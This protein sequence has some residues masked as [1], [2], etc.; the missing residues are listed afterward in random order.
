M[1]NSCLFGHR[2]LFAILSF[3]FLTCLIPSSSV[4][5]A[6][7]VRKCGVNSFSV[8]QRC[9]GN[10]YQVANV[11]C[12]DGLREQLR[13]EGQCVSPA[14]FQQLAQNFCNHHCSNPCAGN[15]FDRD[16]IADA[17]DP[18]LTWTLCTIDQV[19]SG[20]AAC[21]PCADPYFSPQEVCAILA[22]QSTIRISDSDGDGIPQT[23]PITGAQM[24]NCPELAN[25]DQSDLNGNN[26]GDVC[27]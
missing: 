16:G 1:K 15:D 4:Q 18:E 7:A 24:D 8:T 20:V 14:I 27:E 12:H 11:A 2:F 3:I 6:A 5:A 22:D 19:E 26:R 25:P 17:C 10:R 23:H 21:A 9:A 13:A